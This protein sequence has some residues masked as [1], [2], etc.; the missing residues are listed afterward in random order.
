MQPLHDGYIH[1]FV[2][3]CRDQTEKIEAEKAVRDKEIL[4]RLVAGLEDER[5][6]IARDIHDH[7]GQ[8]ITALRLKLEA[9]RKI[10][11]GSEEVCDRIE[12]AQAVAGQLDSD[13]DFIAWELRPAALDDL[14]LRVTLKNFV[15]EWSLHTKVKTD[16]HV[17]GFGARRLSSEIE[18]NL[19]RI[20]QEA[21][22]NIYKY[23]KAKTVS[24]LFEKRKNTVVLIVEDD[25]VGFN[26]ESKK[27]RNKGLG[28]SG[29]GERAKMLGGELEIESAPKQG[30]TVFARVPF[31]AGQKDV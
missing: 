18:T 20:A 25:G 23:A 21:L 19:Y 5:R 29:M 1:G 16:Y 9:V 11:G 12:E 30:T 17:A 28:L 31:A 26:V 14:G 4:Q 15:R 7:F 24:V 10:F 3:I 8:Q 27:N 13:V 2:K 22:N 6:R